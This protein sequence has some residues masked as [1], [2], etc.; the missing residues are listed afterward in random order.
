MDLKSIRKKLDEAGYKTFIKKSAINKD[1]EYLVAGLTDKETTLKMDSVFQVFI[2]KEKILL[3]FLNIQST[4]NRYF[5]S[6]ETLLVFVK[7]K[8]PIPRN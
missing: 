5:N 1:Q 8:F 3:S 7:Q 4:I 2:E 6:T